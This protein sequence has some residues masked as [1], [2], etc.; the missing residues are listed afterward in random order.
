M[1]QLSALLRSIFL[2]GLLGL[3]AACGDSGQQAAPGG[4]TS[5]AESQSPANTLDLYFIYSSEKK[6]WLED[7][8][9]QFNAAGHKTQDGKTIHVEIEAMGSGESVDAVLAGTKKPHLLSPASEVFV[10][11]ANA[12]AEGEGGQPLLPE[13]ENLV[14]SPV[15]VAMWKPMAEALGWGEK[16]IGWEDILNMA[17]NPAGW[18]AYGFPQWGRFKFGH[19]H[20]NYS[21]SGLI[22]LLAQVY[23]A[24]GKR[25]GLSRDDVNQ[26]STARYLHAIQQSIVHY[27]RSTG[28]FGKKL[29]ANGP[30]YLSAAVLYENMV[31][32]S[33][34]HQNLEYPIV[35]VYPKEGTFWSDHPAGIVDRPWVTPAHREAAEAYLK[36]LLERPQQEKAMAYGFRPADVDIA[37]GAPIDAAHGVDPK[38]PQALLRVPSAKVIRAVQ[39]LWKEQK[40]A[41]NIAL[42]MDVS[43]SMKGDKIT[44]ARN[45]G[46]QLLGV[47]IQFLQTLAL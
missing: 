24:T 7:V 33:Y 30:S 25:T 20:P 36:Y 27:G 19:T 43:G 26:D 23:A 6:T 21:N 46:L 1:R 35:A 40:K 34:S 8:T 12:G 45:A 31:I 9:K 5:Q 3:L 18:K 47:G 15:V 22:S 16:P 14:L 2:L 44:Q 10:K 29:M 13:T 39:A 38:E 37:L 11:L 4:G 41:A 42:V 17:Q 32:E 28:F